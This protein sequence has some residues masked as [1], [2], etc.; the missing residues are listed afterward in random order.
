MTSRKNIVAIRGHSVRPMITE[1][2]VKK[3]KLSDKGQISLP[4]EIQREAIRRERNCF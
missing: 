2:T 4:V 1:L 3:V